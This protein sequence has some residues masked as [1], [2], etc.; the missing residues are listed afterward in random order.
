MNNI[1]INKEQAEVILIAPVTGSYGSAERIKVKNDIRDSF[2]DPEFIASGATEITFLASKE[3]L[4]AWA[5]GCI[6]GWQQESITVRG[7]A[8]PLTDA[9]RNLIRLSAKSMRVWE[10]VK[11]HLPKVEAEEGFDVDPDIEEDIKL[12]QPEG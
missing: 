4:K 9:D 3:E 10:Y 5:S 8:V 11:K 1:T 2:L 6:S 12:D 7:M